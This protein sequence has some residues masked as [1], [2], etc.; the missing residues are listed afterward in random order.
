MQPMII[1]IQM[2]TLKQQLLRGK[3][4]MLIFLVIS[5]TTSSCKSSKIGLSKKEEIS[6]FENEIRSFELQDSV[7]I[8][9]ELYNDFIKSFLQEPNSSNFPFSREELK[10]I[11]NPNE[12][13]FLIQQLDRQ[14]FPLEIYIKY[15]NFKNSPPVK[16]Y[17]KRV[18]A[19]N[20]VRDGVESVVSYHKKRIIFSNPIITQTGD[21][22]LIYVTRG[23]YDSMS[24]TIR[25]Y[26]QVKGAWTLFSSLYDWTL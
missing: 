15:Q 16:T 24:S 17:T 10:K 4:L 20:E 9:K 19:K 2:A 23:T 3:H 8:K 14:D 11:I 25:V 22:A 7:L 13:N 5:I 21:Y 6:I 26:K 18:Y 12:V 1:L